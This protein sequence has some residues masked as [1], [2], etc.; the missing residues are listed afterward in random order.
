MKAGA[1]AQMLLFQSWKF[2][3]GDEMF[4]GFVTAFLCPVVWKQCQISYCKANFL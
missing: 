1:S 2:L 4:A 3:K